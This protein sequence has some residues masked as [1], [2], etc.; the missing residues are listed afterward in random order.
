MGKN[1]FV[2]TLIITV[3]FM[4]TQGASLFAEEK[5][6]SSVLTLGTKTQNVFGA[7]GKVE[8][9]DFKP[10]GESTII[11]KTSKGESISVS[12]KELKNDATVLTTFRKEKDK[13]GREK[14]TLISLSIVKTA[15]QAKKAKRKK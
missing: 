3:L 2:I 5:T 15:K 8:Y 4:A 1:L 14:N 7:V 6:E 9:V 10:K 11:L 13:K 12:L